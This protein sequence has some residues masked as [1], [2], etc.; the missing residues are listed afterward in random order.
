[1]HYI[2]LFFLIPT[3]LID[4]NVT[5][6]FRFVNESHIAT[7]W[8]RI[9]IRVQSVPDAFS[10]NGDGALHFPHTVYRRGQRV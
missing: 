9:A 2:V 10:R 5:T 8:T 1:M 4:T 3:A 7:A 6:S